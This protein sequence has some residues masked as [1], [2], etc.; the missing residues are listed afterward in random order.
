MKS[1]GLPGSHILSKIRQ[2]KL[3]SKSESEKW[4][5]TGKSHSLFRVSHPGVL[6]KKMESQKYLSNK[7]KVKVKSRGLSG[8]HILSLDSPIQVCF[9]RRLKAKIKRLK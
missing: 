7:S 4:K 3:K 1:R 5:L 2:I 9:I 8:T 6:Y